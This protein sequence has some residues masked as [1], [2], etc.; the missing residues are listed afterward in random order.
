MPKG[1]KQKLKLY[2]LVKILMEETDDEHFLSMPEIIDKLSRYGVSADRKRIYD[3]MEALRDVGYDIIME[4]KGRSSGYHIGSKKFELAELMLLVDAVQFSKFITPKK[5]NELI[6]KITGLASKFE[7]SQL[8]RN[9]VVQGRVKAENEGIFYTVNDIHQAI[10]DNRRIEFEYLQWNLNKEL[11]PRKEGLYEVSPWALTWDDE[12]YYLIAFDAKARRIKH[13]RVDKMRDVTISD[14]KRDGR[15]Y[16]EKLDLAAYSK[17]NFGMF[18]GDDEIVGIAFKDEFVGVIIDRFGTDIS[19]R[20]YEEEGWSETR[21]SVSV[22]DQFFGWIF[23]LGGSVR[24]TSPSD[25][26]ERFKDEVQKIL[27]YY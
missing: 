13:Y 20:P 6:K 5:S 24:I 18:S 4:R 10:R 19:I 26:K 23:A 1:T 9:V 27:E 16:F 8:K 11:V 7:A 14:K 17:K 2:Y 25:V 12:N 21:V 3:D 15:E 22:S